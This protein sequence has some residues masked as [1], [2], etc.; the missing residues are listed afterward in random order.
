MPCTL[1]WGA[2]IRT[3]AAA[4]G[5][6]HGDA[7]GVT[8][9]ITP[10]DL[11][12]PFATA[13]GAEGPSVVAR[14]AGA[15]P[16]V[17]PGFT[18]SLFASGLQGP[19]VIRTAPDGSIFVSE[20]YANRV[21]RF[22]PDGT[23]RSFAEGLNQPFGIAFWPAGTPRFVYVAETDRVV[24]FPWVPG[25]Q[26]PSGPAQAVVS[27]IPTGGHS[28]RDLAVAPDGTRLFLSVGSGS[29][30]GD[31]I[32]RQPSEG[33]A[34]WQETHGVGAAYGAEAG[35]AA[36]FWLQPDGAGGL[37][38]Y[39]QGLR[40]C[41]GLAMQPGPGT[42]WCVVNERDGLGDNLPPDYATGLRE[43]AFYGWPW[44][45]IGAHPE[46]RLP[47][48]RIDLAG[49]VTMPDVLFQPHS[50]PL[51]ITFYN[52]TAFPPEYRGDAFVAMHGSWNRSV[53]TGYKVVRLHMVNGHPDGTYQDF[54]TGFVASEGAVWGRPVGVA[55]A[56]DGSLLVTEDGNGNIWRIAAATS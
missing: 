32:H 50:A 23:R 34:A 5:D 56:P 21:T 33:L 16:R 11:A 10:A 45:Y 6:W 20:T 14:P 28:T 44:F 7:P 31:D 38:P 18:V 30:D 37:H 29:N 4:Y 46:P 54:L 17:P 3:G 53:R 36:V 15:L 25:S 55:V 24:R 52:G 27:G 26:S 8:R 42:L 47:E 43:G 49:K 22:A 35:R 12:K 41:A 2:D 13:S 9:H 40:N 48:S 51:G 39:A 1:A 19:R